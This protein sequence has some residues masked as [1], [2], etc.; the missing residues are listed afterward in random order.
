M[1]EVETNYDYFSGLVIR[2]KESIVQENSRRYKIEELTNIVEYASI[3]NL[4]D[5]EYWQ[6]TTEKLSQKLQE[7]NEKQTSFIERS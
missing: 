7:G 1:E 3:I 6:R 5:E 2:I 4:D